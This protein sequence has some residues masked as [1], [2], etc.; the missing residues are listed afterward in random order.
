MKL[1]QKIIAFIAM[2]LS[3]MMVVHQFK[4][5]EY[6]ISFILFIAFI[7]GWKAFHI[8]FKEL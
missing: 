1:I 4:K 3:I 2:V 8:T 7:L 5:E 6:L